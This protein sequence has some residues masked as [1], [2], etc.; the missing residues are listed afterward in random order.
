VLSSR[1]PHRW[2][3]L[4]LMLR[5]AAAATA[6]TLLAVHRVTGY[7]R[8]LIVFVVLYAIGTSAAAVASPGILA[9]PV[10][11][12]A[13]ILVFYVLIC[14]SGDWRSPFYLLAL[15]SLALPASALGPRRAVLLGGG[16][17]LAFAVAAHYVGPDPLNLGTQASVETLAAHLVLPPMTCLGVGYAA[18][19]M[20]DLTTE[21]HRAER[22]AIE[23]ERRRIAWELHDSAKQRV[24]AAHL[25]I[26]ALGVDPEDPRARIVDQ[27]LTELQAASA[28]MDTSL[29]ELREPLLGTPLHEAIAAR[30]ADL[31][32]AGGPDITVSGRLDDLPPLQAAH[33]YRIVTEAVTNAI[34]HAEAGTV[35]V[36][37]EP[38]RTEARVTVTDD[39][40]GMPAERRPAS[41]GIMAM[42][43]RARSIG[44]RL[45]VSDAQGGGTTVELTIPLPEQ[46]GTRE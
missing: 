36:V 22:L 18:A 41:T 42:R 43:N 6:V 5:A 9:R 12:V 44:G 13:D 4:L 32:V 39:G 40:R 25:V 20:R 8:E 30:A 3:V 28:E 45:T 34:R 35:R 23:A 2:L 37:L 29:A 46:E 7:D 15:T 19:V 24:H 17:S 38:G 31:S 14:M 33:A 10:A 21:R 11:W 1:S 27:A 16:Y 26:S